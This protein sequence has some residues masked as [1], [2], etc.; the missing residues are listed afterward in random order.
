MGGIAVAVR[1]GQGHR[2][3]LGPGRELVSPVPTGLVALLS[4]LL[5][6]TMMAVAWPIRNRKS[7]SSCL[8]R[9]TTVW[10]SIAA[11]LSIMAGRCACPCWCSFAAGALR[12]SN[13]DRTLALKGFAVL[14]FDAL[15]QG[16]GVGLEIGRNFPSFW[17]AAAI[18]CRSLS[19]LASASSTSY[20][21]DFSDRRSRGATAVGSSP[22]GVQRP[23]PST[24]AVFRLGP[25]RPVA[26]WPGWRPRRPWQSGAS[27]VHHGAFSYQ[28]V[29][30]INVRQGWNHTTESLGSCLDGR[31]SRRQATR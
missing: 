19:I 6:S 18:R 28:E 13:F 26:G 2:R 23:W 10:S 16:E 14:E 21:S 4:A 25:W 15:A 5:G 29:G 1:L 17:P 9:I 22:G 20:C 27:A 7:G 8:F 31:R 12:T 11:T 3:A 24:T 30:Q